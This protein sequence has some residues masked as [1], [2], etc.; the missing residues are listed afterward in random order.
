MRRYSKDSTYS[1]GQRPFVSRDLD[2]SLKPGL[3]LG[4]GIVAEI[5]AVADEFAHP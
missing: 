3:Q 1:C 2:E 5:D 4:F